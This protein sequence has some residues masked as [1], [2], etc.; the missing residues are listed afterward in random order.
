MMIMLENQMILKMFK[1]MTVIKYL[2]KELTN[3]LKSHQ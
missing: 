2:I 3:Q 1:K